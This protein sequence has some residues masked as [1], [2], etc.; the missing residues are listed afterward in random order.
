MDPD[1]G[2]RE[3]SESGQLV[4]SRMIGCLNVEYSAG[5]AAAKLIERLDSWS[6]SAGFVFATWARWYLVP[7]RTCPG[8]IQD[9]ANAVHHAG[10]QHVLHGAGLALQVMVS[11]DE[12]HVGQ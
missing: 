10:V 12:Q 11:L 3:H 8:M 2:S 5:L 9:G 4:E 1:D 7:V 6:G